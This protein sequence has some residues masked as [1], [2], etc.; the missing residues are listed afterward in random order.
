MMCLLMLLIRSV[1]LM[2]L[3]VILCMLCVKKLLCSFMLEFVLCRSG[4]VLV[5]WL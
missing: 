4:G 5:W 3:G 1:V 2:I